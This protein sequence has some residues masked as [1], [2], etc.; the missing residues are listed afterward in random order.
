MS[1]DLVLVE[2]SDAL[3]P[4]RAGIPYLERDEWRA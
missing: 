1:E 3:R 4:A 2:P